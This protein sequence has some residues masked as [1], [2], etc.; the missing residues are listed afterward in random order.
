MSFPFNPHAGLIL[1]PAEVEGPS[2]MTVLKLAVDT[3]ATNTLVS[4]GP[5]VVRFRIT[6]QVSG[7][8]SS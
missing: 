5:L 3:G 2:G 7:V 4:N 1:V 8:V 6:S